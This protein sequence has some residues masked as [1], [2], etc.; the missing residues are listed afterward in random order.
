[1]HIGHRIKEIFDTK[2]KTCTV[3][4]LARRLCC[5]RR[6]IYNIFAR[7]TIDTDLL[8]RLSRILDHN[9][10]LDLADDV[11]SPDSNEPGEQV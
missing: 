11:D 2:P 5:D 9:F 4:W 7:P 3:T 10:F 1:M 6:N 8:R